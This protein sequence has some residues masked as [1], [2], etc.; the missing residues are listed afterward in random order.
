MESDQSVLNKQNADILMRV[1]PW[2]MYQID[3]NSV[4]LKCNNR[5]AEMFGLQSDMEIV[6]MTYERIA[7]LCNWA[8]E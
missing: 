3:R 2:Y 6:G 4:F 8:E 5:V 1:L 7:K